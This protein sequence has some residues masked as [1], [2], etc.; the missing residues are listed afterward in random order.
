MPCTVHLLFPT[1]LPTCTRILSRAFVHTSPIIDALF[2]H[3]DTPAGQAEAVTSFT[4]SLS[5]NPTAHFLKAVDDNTGAI[6]GWGEWLVMDQGLYVEEKA[7]DS[8]WE[9]EA[10]REWAGVLWAPLGAVRAQAAERAGG[11]FLLLNLLCV[12]PEYQRSGAGTAL[13]RWGTKIADERGVEAIL[14]A[15][16]AGRHLYE[17]NGFEVVEQMKW[18]I[19]EKFAGRSTPQLYFMRRPA[20]KAAA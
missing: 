3:H 15:T 17:Q 11:R 13:M 12:D 4:K 7:D 10:E 8:K 18:E 19:S 14:E 16:P 6:L 1:D 5:T 20:K 2:P 9:S